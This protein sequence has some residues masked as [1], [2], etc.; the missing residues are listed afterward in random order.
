MQDLN[1]AWDVSTKRY[2]L[3]KWEAT[4]QNWGAKNILNIEII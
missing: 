4:D 3:F 1:R 2:T